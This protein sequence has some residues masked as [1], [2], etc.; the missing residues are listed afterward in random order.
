MPNVCKAARTFSI[1]EKC[2]HSINLLNVTKHV[3]VCDG[4]G[5]HTKRVRSYKQR[6]SIFERDQSF[7]NDIQTYYDAGHNFME[8]VKHFNIN[9]RALTLL[10]KA[11]IIKTRTK[12][13]TA[14]LRCKGIY[15][16]NRS[17]SPDVRRKISESRRR[18]LDAHPEKV[19][20]V[21]NHSSKPSYPEQI[22]REAL[23]RKSIQGWVYQYQM[24]RY[25]YDFAFVDAKLDVEIDGSTHNLEKVKQIDQARD[26]YSKSQGWDVLRIPA[27][28]VL[29]DVDACVKIV[30]DRLEFRLKF[31]PKIV[32]HT[33]QV[34]LR[35]APS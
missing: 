20:Y 12:T 9:T 32:D 18:Y 15:R 6:Q 7:Y 11:N 13:E 28:D 25:Q 1:C 4:K 33:T 8:T 5:P 30:T 34:L 17:V 29:S 35:H 10:V 16:P 24:S 3:R 31:R 21:L 2:G 14:K 27:K 23:E 26:E 19:P 22:F